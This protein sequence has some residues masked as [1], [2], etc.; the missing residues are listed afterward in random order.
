MLNDEQK[1]TL[2]TELLL[3][4]KLSKKDALKA[5]FTKTRGLD[6]NFASLD[7]DRT[8]ANILSAI[9]QP[10]VA[11]VIDKPGPLTNRRFILFSV[12]V[13]LAG[14]AILLLVP[15]NKFVIFPVFAL[16]YMIQF[17]YQPAMTALSQASGSWMIS[18]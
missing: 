13:I 17:V 11:G 2:C 16:I 15:N 3:K 1:A 9:L 4:E 8:M 10:L 6:L 7:G 5:L 12:L 14:S 18:I